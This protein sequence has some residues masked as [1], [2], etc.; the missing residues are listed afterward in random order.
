MDPRL[1]ALARNLLDPSLDL[2]PGEKLLI[3]GETGCEDLVRV[4]IGEA[5][6]RGAQP[7]FELTDPV[8]RRRSSWG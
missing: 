7:F 1:E 6:A 5:H 3:E 4:L 8:L 2:Q